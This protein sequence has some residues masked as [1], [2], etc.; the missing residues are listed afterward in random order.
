MQGLNDEGLVFEGGHPGG[1][2]IGGDQRLYRFDNGY[3]A[4]VV[5]GS[6]I[7]GGAPFELAVLAYIGPGEWDFELTYATPVAEDVER[8]DAADVNRMLSEI[9][10]LPKRG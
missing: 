7:T 3:G 5:N 2:M 1:A 8:G 10:A 6:M 4:S 9:A